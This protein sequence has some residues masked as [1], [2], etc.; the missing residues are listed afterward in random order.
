MA[1]EAAAHTFAATGV[2]GLCVKMPLIPDSTVRCVKCARSAGRIV[3]SVF[4]PDADGPPPVA[5]RS[6][7]RCGECGAGLYLE[8]EQKTTA[9]QATF[10]D[11]VRRAGTAA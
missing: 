6:G 1:A 8:P 2:L 11:A 4:V 3:N 7:S 9:G 10:V 5:R